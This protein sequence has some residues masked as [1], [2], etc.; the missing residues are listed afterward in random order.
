[1]FSNSAGVSFVTILCQSRLFS[2][3][4]ALKIAG[5]GTLCNHPLSIEAIFPTETLPLDMDCPMICN[6]PL[7]IEAIFPTCGFREDADTGYVVTILCQSR[8]FSPREAPA[9]VHLMLLCNHPLSIEAI[10]PTFVSSTNAQ[11]IS[12]SV[13]ILCQSRLFS[14]LSLR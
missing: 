1:M 11:S 13:T 12:Y 2:P 4:E 9:T 7:S 14:P 6:H 3:L 8:L 10:F 5:E